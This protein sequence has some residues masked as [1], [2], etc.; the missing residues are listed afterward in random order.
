MDG[1]I[2]IDKLISE[3]GGM[4]LPKHIQCYNMT[5]HG[6]YLITKKNLIKHLALL[7]VVH[8]A[9]SY[10]RLYHFHSVKSMKFEGK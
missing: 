7:S 2:N 10:A 6:T 9:M 4:N 5:H 3:G 1:H 8:F